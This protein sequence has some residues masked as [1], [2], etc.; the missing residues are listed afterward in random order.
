MKVS[1]SIMEP[2]SAL[3][4]SSGAPKFVNTFKEDLSMLA[5]TIHMDN[6]RA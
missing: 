1:R 4:I 5:V 6:V 3:E 2:S